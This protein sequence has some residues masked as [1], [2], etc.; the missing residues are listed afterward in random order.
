VWPGKHGSR[1]WRS[2]M[3]DYLRFYADALA[4]C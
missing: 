4:Q 1:Y 3:G 2:H